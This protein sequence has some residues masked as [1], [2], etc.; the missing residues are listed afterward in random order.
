MHHVELYDKPAADGSPVKHT[1]QLPGGWDELQPDHLQKVAVIQATVQD[2]AAQRFLLLEAL[3]GIPPE[4]MARLPDA[5]DLTYQGKDI[6]GYDVPILLPWLDWAFEEPAYEF[7]LL[8]ELKVKDLQFRGPDSRLDR[9]EAN[10]FAYTDLLL[11]QY[12]ES[13]KVEDLDRLLG[14]MYQPHYASWTNEPIEEYAERLAT[15]PL[16]TKLAAILNYRALRGYV[17]S[18]YPRVF[19]GGGGEEPMSQGFFGTLYDVAADGV[20][21]DLRRVERT[22]LHDVLGYLEHK[23]EQ[24]E[25]AEANTPEAA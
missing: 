25:R 9:W 2:P 24:A 3:A 21:G 23:M 8:P 12:G 17:A 10:Q 7:S 19:G 18:Q 13:G 1:F 11:R 14:C 15:T 22:R 5:D 16:P 4:L 20:F 6:G